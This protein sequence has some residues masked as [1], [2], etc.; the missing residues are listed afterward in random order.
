MTTNDVRIAAY[1]V[2]ESRRSS[3][4]ITGTINWGDAILA[5]LQVRRLRGHTHWPPP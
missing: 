1:Q 5:S 2:L 3:Y 4:D